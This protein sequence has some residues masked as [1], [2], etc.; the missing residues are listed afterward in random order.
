AGY[1]PFDRNP[2]TENPENGMISTANNLS[3]MTPITPIGILTGYFRP[4]D[5]AARIYE[6]LAERE[7]WDMEGLKK[8]QTDTRLFSGPAMTR[9]ILDVLTLQKS[10]F[11]DQERKGLEALTAWDGFMGTDSIGGTIFQFTTYHIVKQAL[12]PHIGPDLLKA[13]LNQVDYWSYLKEFLPSDNNTITGRTG[14]APTT[15]EAIVLAGFKD[16]VRELVG[17]YGVD[18]A[19]WNW[20]AVHT[21]EFAHAMGKKKPLDFFFNIGPFPSPAEFTS[22]NKLKSNIGDHDYKVTSIPST[23]RLIDCLDPDNTWSILPTGNS[24]NFKSPFYKDQAEMYITGQYRKVLF[25]EEQYM[26]DDAK[27]LRM[28]PQ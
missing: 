27:V 1:L 19:K 28:V 10:G 11:S 3:T 7:K 5:R 15:K 20:G 18:P 13:Y 23:R 26:T 24:G 9:A 6:L 17:K 25:T 2:Q 4:D 22:V 14:T 16:A 21:I 12:E 8:I